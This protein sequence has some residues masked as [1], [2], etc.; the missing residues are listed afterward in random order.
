MTHPMIQ[1]II[2]RA[3][4]T[5]ETDW[6]CV[7]F[8]I[9]VRKQGG[10][11]LRS[12]V[13]PELVRHY[14]HSAP[15]TRYKGVPQPG[16]RLLQLGQLTV[17]M[18][19]P[20][21]SDGMAGKLLR[22]ERSLVCI[23]AVAVAH[24]QAAVVTR[25]EEIMH[26]I[27]HGANAPDYISRP[28]YSSFA[29]EFISGG[30]LLQQAGRPPCADFAISR[31]RGRPSQPF[32]DWAQGYEERDLVRVRMRTPRRL[33]EWF[34][35]CGELARAQTPA[36]P[37]PEP[38][39]EP[40]PTVRLHPGLAADPTTHILGWLPIASVVALSATSRAHSAYLRTHFCMDHLPP[41]HVRAGRYAG[42][43]PRLPL[44]VCPAWPSDLEDTDWQAPNVMGA[45]LRCGFGC[46]W[47]LGEGRPALRHLRLR[48]CCHITDADLRA[49]ARDA[50]STTL[51]GCT[52]IHSRR[53]GLHVVNRILPPA[54][55][56]HPPP[57][58]LVD[59]C[60]QMDLLDLSRYA[61]LQHLILD[62]CVGLEQAQFDL[63]GSQV[64]LSLAHTGIRR[65]NHLAR[66]RHLNLEGCARVVDISDLGHHQV[67]LNVSDIPKLDW[68]TA[69]GLANVRR[70]TISG[71]PGTAARWLDRVPNLWVKGND[72]TVNR[73]QGS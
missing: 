35:R 42:Q 13:T 37:E 44:L 66:V 8:N 27:V 29:E 56:L 10:D 26:D 11:L 53:E 59:L 4:S 17:S 2:D 64:S 12:L 21:T 34:D 65:V 19:M 15:E 1:E 7:L 67:S 39:P 62:H 16:A 58:G 60:G 51:Y 49:I 9:V 22:S 55:M 31:L 38:E 41:T 25:V 24:D 72:S 57:P 40:K 43:W 6:I 14:I 30:L 68:R 33:R 36:Q 48:G 70:L 63:L 45:G 32:E 5:A 20:V 28:F 50:I 46:R 23:R 52:K 69:T 61:H 71:N 18:D 47:L 54:P 3:V 73:V